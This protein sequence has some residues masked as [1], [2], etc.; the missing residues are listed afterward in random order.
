ML[1]AHVKGE[2][3]LPAQFILAL[4]RGVVILDVLLRLRQREHT[5]NKQHALQ[6]CV[7]LLR[8]TLSRGSAPFQ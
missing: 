8:V 3:L 6:H 4:V 5:G 7:G 2:H 1:D